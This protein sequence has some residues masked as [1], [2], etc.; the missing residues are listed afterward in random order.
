MSTMIGLEKA[1]AAAKENISAEEEEERKK[2]KEMMEEKIMAAKKKNWSE[3]TRSHMVE[4]WKA[5]LDERADSVLLSARRYLDYQNQIVCLEREIRECGG[6]CVP[7]LDLVKD[8]IREIEE[9]KNKVDDL[10]EK[11]YSKM[12]S[13]LKSIAPQSGRVVGRERFDRRQ[14]FEMSRKVMEDTETM[15]RT[16][17]QMI[18][19]LDER[20]G[21]K[22]STIDHIR[23]IA[24]EQTTALKQVCARLD[25]RTT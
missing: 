13:K 24:E 21:S 20:A 23:G 4:S 16:L 6:T 1:S 25:R 8:D 7:R 17:N 2:K 9:Q 10:Y 12:K 18:Q 3:N 19:R 11:V 14:I 5:E 22:A 15:V